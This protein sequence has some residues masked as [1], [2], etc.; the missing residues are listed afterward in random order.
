MGITHFGTAPGVQHHLLPFPWKGEG[1]HQK[2][3]M[4][5]LPGGHLG[6]ATPD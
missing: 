1:N 5:F 3:T 2:E 4:Q 6:K